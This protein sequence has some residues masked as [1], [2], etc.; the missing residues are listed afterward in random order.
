MNKSLLTLISILISLFTMNAQNND[1]KKGDKHF[2]G[3]E[4]VK[5]IDDY[6]KVS[7]KRKSRHL[8]LS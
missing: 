5:A 3:L 2:D 4:Y 8:C 7:R 6:E 1:T